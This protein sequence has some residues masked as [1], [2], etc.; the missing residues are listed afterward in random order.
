MFNEL[1]NEPTRWA[2]WLPVALGGGIAI[3]FRLPREPPHWVGLAVLVAALATA[4]CLRGP[5]VGLAIAVGLA[6][7]ACGFT[8]A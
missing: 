3:Y 2:L 7:G 8:A 1:A 5:A 6:V 4:A